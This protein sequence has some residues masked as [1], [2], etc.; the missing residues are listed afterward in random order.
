MRSY[1]EG[2]VFLR[3]RIYHMAYCRNGHEFS[4]SARTSDEKKAR[5][6]LAHRL[7]EKEK[8]AFVGPSEKRLTL[9]DLEAE[10][11]ADYE[12]NGKRSLDTAMYC[13]KPVKAF[14]KYDR[15]VEI[16]RTRIREYQSARLKEG[17]GALN[18]KSGGPLPAPRL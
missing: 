7:A 17:M 4:E 9:E 18:G 15:L 8:Q 2:R 12:R 1:G 11:V 3:G 10:I 5:K 6:L 14:F 16:T 13:L